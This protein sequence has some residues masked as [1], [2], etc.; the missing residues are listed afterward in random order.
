MI[1]RID[2]DVRT[3]SRVEQVLE[4]GNKVVG[5]FPSK[6]S[7][8]AATYNC[9][10]QSLVINLAM[11]VSRLYDK[12]SRRFSP[13]DKDLA[14][15]PLMIRIVKQK[16]C[17]KRII[18]TAF[19]NWFPVDSSEYFRNKSKDDAK[20]AIDRAIQIYDEK[21]ASAQH[22]HYR[23][24][25]KRLRDS[26]L[27]HSKLEEYLDRKPTYNHL[28]HLMAAAREITELLTL[29]VRGHN[30]RYSELVASIESNANDFWSKALRP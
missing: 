12:G 13:N 5:S 18:D 9:I 22:R 21:V 8:R 11:T 19:R 2:V 7:S 27:A 3:G 28:F 14:S 26:E 16:R 15:I 6:S 23:T 1:E 25:L 24:L 29:A 10:K 20:T 4:A 17:Q 30:I